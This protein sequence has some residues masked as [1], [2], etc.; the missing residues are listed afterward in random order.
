VRAPDRVRRGWLAYL[1]QIVVVA[2]VYL[3]SGK[4]GLDLAFATRSVTAIW[5]PTGIALAALVL[6]G[7][8]LWPA[9]AL[10]ALLTNV[11]TGVPAVTVL[12]ITIG[13]TLEAVAGAYLLRRI[14]GFR[15]SLER[16]RDV[17]ALVGLGAVISTTVSA[18]IGV[19]S[20]LIG[21][22]IAFEHL[23][24]VWRTWWLGDMG[25]DLIVAPAVLIA[26]A[27]RPLTR[28][29]GG[30]IEAAALT[31][32][33]A[34]AS[35]LVFSHSTNLAYLL[36]PLLSWAALRFWQPGAAAGGLLI[37]AVAVLFT[38][39]GQGPFATSAPDERLLLAQTFVGVASV[40]ALVLAAVTRERWRADQAAREIS[41][42]LQASLIPRRLPTVSNIDHAAYF[43]AAG[44]QN[45]V[46]GDFYDLFE[47]SHG[48]W[49]L[50]IGDVGGKGAR[51][52]ALTAL[53]RHTLR[54]A[55]TREQLPSRV[56]ASLN[57]AIRR[58]NDHP[59]ATC[60]AIYATLELNARTVLVSIASGGHPLPL[61]LRRDGSV[62]Q[63][64]EP[65]TV[66]GLDPNPSLSDHNA[67]LAPR[68]TLLLYT[69]GLTD[70]F[71]PRRIV[72]P[73]E[74][75]SILRSCAGQT[76]PQIIASIERNLLTLDGLEPRDDV[77]ILALQV[78]EP[79]D[80][81]DERAP[82][83]DPRRPTSPTR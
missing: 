10:G 46:G 29:P 22:V 6:G 31:L 58:Q 37:A 34:S 60:T 4:L 68:D 83:A 32:A 16:V 36:F 63:L 3:V 74:L 38:A 21:S 51:A 55:S 56:L 14:A 19:I 25:G 62:T 76:P 5:P 80:D 20:L 17:L 82:A 47:V 50:T 61:I 57:D 66:L 52:A 44:D 65:G 1:P 13:N 23:P 8:R 28:L 42:T 70:A 48:R 43:H 78:T 39:N 77:A 9:V 15:P 18:T 81:A 24:S 45:P 59:G 7:Y 72:D 27:Y 69:D 30:R 53:A 40:S 33:L 26:V 64:G 71:A 79:H 75:R 54:A 49:A 12:G 67:T 11:N 73:S 41:A 35:S 2:A